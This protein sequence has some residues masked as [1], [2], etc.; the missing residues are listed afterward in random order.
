M[1][2]EDQWISETYNFLPIDN[3]AGDTQFVGKIVTGCNT[4]PVIGFGGAERR[5][6][7]FWAG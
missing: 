1:R 3:L 7:G 2:S 4:R 5:I 6:D